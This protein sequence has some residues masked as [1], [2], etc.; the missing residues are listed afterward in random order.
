MKY[1]LIALTVCISMFT[2]SAAF[3]QEGSADSSDNSTSGFD[4]SN[5]PSAIT[6][7]IKNGI[8]NYVKNAKQATIQLEWE[9]LPPPNIS[10]TPFPTNGKVITCSIKNTDL[11]VSEKWINSLSKECKNELQEALMIDLSNLSNFHSV[12]ASESQRLNPTENI[13]DS[14]QIKF[15]EIWSKELKKFQGFWVDEQGKGFNLALTSIPTPQY[16]SL[17]RDHLQLTALLASSGITYAIEAEGAQGDFPK[18]ISE[19]IEW[20]IKV[21]KYKISK[22]TSYYRFSAKAIAKP[23]K[24]TYPNAGDT[25]EKTITVNMQFTPGEGTVGILQPNLTFLP[26][27]FSIDLPPNV[28]S[29]LDSTA[30]SEL[31]TAI[32]FLGGFNPTD[33]SNLFGSNT[34]ASIITGGLIGDGFVEPISGVNLEV[35]DIG[36]AKGG[37]I[38]GVGTIGTTPLYIGP[39]LQYSVLTF[40]AGAR[41]SEQNESTSIDPAGLISL[42]LSQLIGGKKQ[43]KSLIVDNNETGGDWGKVSDE[44]SSNLAFIKWNNS[45]INP[46]SLIMEKDCSRQDIDNKNKAQLFFN[47]DTGY[48]FVPRG[49]YKYQMGSAPE[50][51]GPFPISEDAEV[52]ICANTSFLLLDF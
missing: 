24:L 32:S 36:R 46:I 8:V 43:I 33:S 12:E 13:N 41:I 40:S 35:F 28:Q 15:L 19:G 29:L 25:K 50:T 39:S 49:I 20:K 27:Q 52:T 14:S 4:I 6:A 2:G 47:T 45:S 22:D 26:P 51:D 7:S 42:D 34:E 37:V 3:S 30:P 31:E 1:K 16:F 44:I 18:Y 5:A 38:F 9:L 23:L 10:K 11:S 21:Y 17:L 48:R